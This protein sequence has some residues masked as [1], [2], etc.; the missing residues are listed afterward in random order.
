MG[1]T[2]TL[3]PRR[4]FVPPGVGTR[5]RLCIALLVAVV[6]AALAA[7][8]TSTAGAAV[9]IGNCS[10]PGG[11]PS[12]NASLEF[13]VVQAVNQF[14]AG[15][16]LSQLAISPSL[17]AASEWK[18]VHMATYGYMQHP[19]PAEGAPFSNPAR[20]WDDRVLT[21]GYPVGGFVGAGE[22]IAFGYSSVSSVMSA[23]IAS[24]PHYANLVNPSW[25][26]M[27]AGVAFKGATGYWSQ[28]FGTFNNAAPGA[29]FAV[30]MRSF[31]GRAVRHGVVLHWRTASEVDTAGF[32]VYR[33]MHGTRIRINHFLIAAAG[34]G[35]GGHSYTFRDRRAPKGKR[36]VTY[37]LQSVDLDATKSWHG[38]V[39]VARR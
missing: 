6:T 17:T 29:N 30:T 39:R 22:N 35:G 18:A 9:V 8:A 23:W 24:P 25:T 1:P 27:G 34:K 15:M 2:C 37:W 19:D 4:G 36:T 32:R 13:Q 26:V 38:P 20:N 7:S 3:G 11:T 16:G 14:R 10:I 21:C 33:V 12:V 5:I 31:S 28:D